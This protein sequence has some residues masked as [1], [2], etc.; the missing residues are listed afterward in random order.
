MMLHSA[1]PS[2]VNWP[3]NCEAI[4]THCEL[5]CRLSLLSLE[6]K[7]SWGTVSKALWKSKNT[8]PS[9]FIVFLVLEPIMCHMQKCR[10]S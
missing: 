2:V 4:C 5:H 9:Y 8:A 1:L 10:D 6:S 7:G 3:G